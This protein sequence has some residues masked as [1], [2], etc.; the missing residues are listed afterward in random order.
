MGNLVILYMVRKVLLARRTNEMM[1]KIF[2]PL[3]LLHP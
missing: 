3:S 2:V 1:T